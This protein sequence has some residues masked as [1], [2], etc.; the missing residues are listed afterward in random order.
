MYFIFLKRK[1]TWSNW[2]IWIGKYIIN[3][4]TWSKY[5]HAASTFFKGGKMYVGEAKMA[6]ARIIELSKFLKEEGGHNKV[7]AYKVLPIVSP[8]RLLDFNEK[9]IGSEFDFKGAAR[10]AIKIVDEDDDK[11]F[12]SE[13]EVKLCQ[14]LGLLS[15]SID[16]STINPKEFLKLLKRNGLINP[17][18]EIW[19]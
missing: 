1:V 2:F 18:P 8:T 12:C 11:V 15:K 13:R 9:M 7:Y 19:R 3:L 5:H 4:F 6:G 10:A 17:K 16:A 14:E